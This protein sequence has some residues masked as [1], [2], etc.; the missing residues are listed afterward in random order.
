MTEREKIRRLDE[1]MEET[2]AVRN[3]GYFGANPVMV[4]ANVFAVFL[5]I[6]PIRELV[7]VLGSFWV[8]FQGVLLWL[9]G[10]YRMQWLLT[11]TVEGRQ[12]SWREFFRYVPVDWKEYRRH[13]YQI[14]LAYTGKMFLCFAILQAASQLLSGTLARTGYRW[15]GLAYAAVMCFCCILLPGMSRIRRQGC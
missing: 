13:R 12:V 9:G 6:I 4:M 5:M 11:L 7:Q 10:Y 15:Q 2:E 3:S 8:L 14:L 1:R